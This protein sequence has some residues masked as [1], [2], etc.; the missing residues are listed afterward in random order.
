L[1]DAGFVPAWS[2]MTASSP[3]REIAA[4]FERLAADTGDAAWLSKFPPVA[5]FEGSPVAKAI[6]ALGLCSNAEAAVVLETIAKAKPTADDYKRYHQ[7]A[8]KVGGHGRG[9]PHLYNAAKSLDEMEYLLK[10]N[11]S[12]SINDAAI[13]V[14]NTLT[15]PHEACGAVA[16]LAGMYRREG[17][18]RPPRKILRQNGDL[19]QMPGPSEPAIDNPSKESAC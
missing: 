6:A 12:R 2:G 9:R 8:L 5:T 16:R 3:K 11:A 19:K 17:R 7:A 18:Y 15:D 13:K 10:K 14:K 4:V 1:A